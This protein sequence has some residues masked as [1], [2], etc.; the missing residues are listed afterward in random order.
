MAIEISTSI[1]IAAGQTVS[2]VDPPKYVV[3]DFYA[4]R[5][6]YVFNKSFLAPVVFTNHGTVELTLNLPGYAYGFG[7]ARTSGTS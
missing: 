3:N 6:A 5:P 7:I 4:D 2:F 1:E